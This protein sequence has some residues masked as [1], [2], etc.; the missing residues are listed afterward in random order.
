MCNGR[1]TECASGSELIPEVHSVD[2]NIR[3]HP[4]QD[5]RF[6]LELK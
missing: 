4:Y 3:N 5:V 6:Y 2:E 1:F